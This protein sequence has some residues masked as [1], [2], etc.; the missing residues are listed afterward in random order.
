ME[1]REKGGA[2]TTSSSSDRLLQTDHR[3]HT[4]SRLERPV[5]LHSPF[6][7]Q[8]T[9]SS[10]A[11]NVFDETDPMVKQDIHVM[12]VQYLQE[13]ELNESAGA[14]MNEL[15]IKNSEL[16]AKRYTCG[17]PSARHAHLIL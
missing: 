4:V 1:A 12:I 8:V 3:R 15:A 11:V 7:R 9:M 14:I 10:C 5:P 6:E 16:V 17:C 2:R 13:Q